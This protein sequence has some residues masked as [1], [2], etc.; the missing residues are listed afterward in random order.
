MGWGLAWW[1]LVLYWVAGAFYINQV[2]G[3]VRAARAAR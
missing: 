1:G 2:V 3:A